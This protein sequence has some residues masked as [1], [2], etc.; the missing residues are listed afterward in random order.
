MHDDGGH[1]CGPKRAG[2]AAPVVSEFDAAAR[3]VTA[4]SPDV[5]LAL[6][7]ELVRIDGG[8]FDMG[9]RRSRY[10]QDHDSPRRR[11]RVS[12][13]RIS[14]HAVTNAEYARFVD[15]TG[16]LTVAE[17]EGW[18][19]VFHLFLKDASRHPD[20]AAGAP[21]WR[22]VDGSC[23][24]APEGPGSDWKDRA[25][26]PA[27]HISWFDALAYCRWAGLRL[28]SEAEWEYAARG[29]LQKKKFPW[30]NDMMPNGRHA[31]NTWQGDFPQIDSAED[32]W[33]GSAPVRS[34]P[35][36]GYGLYEM[37][38]NVWEWVQDYFD[39]DP[40]PQRNAVR[41]PR[42]PGTGT[43]R[44]QRGGSYLC[45]VSYCDRYHVHSRTRNDPGSSS[46]NSGFRVAADAD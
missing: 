26:H 4:A 1:C 3:S 45:H 42:G 37:T 14:P 10:P 11:V 30:G 16:Y 44:V 17:R 41:D 28:P 8:F 36:N 20:Y 40:R 33:T 24:R 18:S 27:V 43:E 38:G 35:P 7:E 34:F 6:R 31:M 13:F 22:R 5:G 19:F 21:W 2:S 15:A 12:S 23:W 29:G 39:P 46:G 9:A 25:D 32:G